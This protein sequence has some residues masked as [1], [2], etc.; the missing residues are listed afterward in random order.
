MKKKKDKDQYIK[1]VEWSEKDQCFIGS[2]PGFIGPCCHG[3]DEE[4]VF[5][6]LC[7]ILDEWVE[8]HSSDGIPLPDPTAGKEYSG[9]FILRISKELHK[10][11]S[12]KAMQA[13]LSLNQFCEKLFERNVLKK[14]TA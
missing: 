3:K 4:K 1:L 8:I 6:E 11:L 12:L 5:G 9:K 7:Q 13:N 14:K 10:V 2:V